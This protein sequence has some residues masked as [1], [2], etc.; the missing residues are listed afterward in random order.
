MRQFW[1]W[2]LCCAACLA[3]GAE[4]TTVDTPGIPA[5]NREIAELVTDRPDFTESSEI[6][7]KGWLQWESGFSWYREGVNRSAVL[8]AP[9]LRFG[10]TKRLELRLSTDGYLR[11]RGEGVDIRAGKA[12]GGIGFKFKFLDESKYLPAMSIISSMSV[13]NGHE[14][15]TCGHYDPLTKLT[16]AKE[17]FWG[18][19]ASGNINFAAL[20]D[21]KGRWNQNAY[22][23][24][25]GHG[26]TERFGGYW[27]VY[28][29]NSDERD[30]FRL[31]MFQTGLTMAIGKHSQLDVSVGKSLTAHGPDGMIAFG[32]A[33]RT[34]YWTS[35]MKRMWH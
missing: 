22:T 6:A 20:S 33:T 7:P 35:A 30:G 27:E 14:F 18:F 31:T 16:F 8:G 19:E 34:P 4:Q 9:L 10:L 17:L 29:F 13:P 23:L 5:K 32:W 15:F 26:F 21:E 12:D 25:I 2:Q 24:S 28:T 1:A 3:M 11:E